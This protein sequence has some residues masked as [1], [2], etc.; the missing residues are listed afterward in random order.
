MGVG[1]RIETRPLI[2]VGWSSSNHVVLNGAPLRIVIQKR[3]QILSVGCHDITFEALRKLV[4]FIDEQD[5][6][7]VQS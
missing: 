4:S 5:E 6:V 1:H 2:S 3:K 7:V